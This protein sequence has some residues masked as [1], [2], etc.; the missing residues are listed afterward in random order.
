MD[1]Q[2]NLTEMLTQRDI[3]D[4]HKNTVFEALK[5]QDAAKYIYPI[6]ENLHILPAEDHLATFSRWLYLE[7]K[8]KAY[9]K[10]L[11]KT[12]QQVKDSYDYIIIDTPPALSDQTVNALTAS[13]AVVCNFET[14]KFC[15]SALERFLETVIHVQDMVNP[16]LEVA[17]ILNT[18]IDSRR[19]DTNA[20]IE[21]VQEN[22]P[23]LS[24]NTIIKRRASVGR[25][26]IYGFQDN[27]E[28]R[29]VIKQYDPFVKE[30]IN[31]VG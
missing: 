17:G 11:D 1:S 4:F 22:Y 24:F 9:S 28:L 25:V 18:I 15:Y 13:D 27:P 21:L 19:S 12:L 23:D 30:L 7:S 16:K 26:S 29:E 5:E 8:I 10:V 3:Y 14:S 20:L 2:G 31:R 6:E